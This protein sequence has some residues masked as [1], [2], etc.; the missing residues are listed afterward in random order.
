MVDIFKVLAD[1]NR[2]RILNLLRK[3][4]LCVCE[5]EAILDTT[6]SNVSRHLTRLRND[7]LVSFEKRAQWIYYSLHPEFIKDHRLLFDY[8]VHEMD[9]NEA[10]QADEK[11]L[12]AYRASSL[13]C[14]TVT[15]INL[16][17]A[18]RK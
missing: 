16:S 18:L 11:R 14:E 1:E 15:Q 5:I 6:Q 2:L 3:D 10:Y 7:K 17:E 13:T 8:L 9:Q 4:E 12:A